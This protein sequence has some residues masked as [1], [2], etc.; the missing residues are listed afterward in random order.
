MPKV[1]PLQSSF[2]GGEITPLGYGL[3]DADKYK[4]GMGFCQNYIPTLQGPLL[5]RPGDKYV[6]PVADAT[7]PPVLIPFK[8]SATQAYML[9]FGHQYIRFY[10]N[11][12]QVLAT[13]TLYQVV[14]HDSNSIGTFT[15]NAVR[16]TLVPLPG[17]I[18]T[19]SVPVTAATPLSLSTPYS[20]TTTTQDTASIRYIQN[21]DVMY[22]FHPK[23]PVLK[24]Q[25][26]SNYEWTLKQVQFRDGPYQKLNTYTT[27]GDNVYTTMTP[28]ANLGAVTLT[29]GPT[30]AITGCANNGSGL[31]RVTAASST[32]R[33]T[34]DKIVIK[35]V[36][37]TTEANNVFNTT[38]AA[39]TWTITVV[40]NT[41]FDLIG[42]TFTNAYTSGGTVYPAVFMPNQQVAG[43][44]DVGRAF[45]CQASDG[46]RRWGY[47]FTVTDPSLAIWYTAPGMSA[48]PNL[49]ALSF[50][51]LGIFIPNS[52][53]T[54]D[55]PATACFHQN[56]LIL[57]GMPNQPQEVDGS[58]S[59]DFENFA[60]SN[61]ATLAV[62]DAYAYQFTLNSTDQN[63]IR[64][65]RS[66]AQGLLAGTQSSEW[67]L[68]ASSQNQA[69]SATNFSAS[70][71]SY[72]GSSAVDA[73]QAGNATLHLQSSSRKLRELNYFFQ[74]GTFRSTDLSEMA[75]HL[76]APGIVKLA[77]QKETQP[78]LWALR[79]DGMLLTMV[80]NRDDLTLKAGWARQPLG[81]QS[82]ASGTPPIVLSMAVIPSPDGSFEQLW[83][84]VK[85]WINGA[86]VVFIEYLTKPYDESFVQ[87]DAYHFDCGATYDNPITT[88]ALQIVSTVTI[89]TTTTLT[90]TFA[91]GLSN[92]DQVRLSSFVGLNKST[93]DI[94][95]NITTTNLVN[96]KAFT[97]AA[98][99]STTFQ[100]QDSYGNAIVSTGYSA[101]VAPSFIAGVFVNGGQIR[102][103]VSTVSGLT[104]LA[105][106]TVS[107][108]ADGGIH[109]DVVVSS[110]G[111]ITLNYPAAK[112]QIGYKYNSDGQNLRLEA[113]AADGT[114]I[115][116]IRRPERAAFMLRFVG[117]FAMGTT[118][119]NLIPTNFTRADVN[120]AD[121]ATTLF[122]GIHRD[123]VESS[124]DFE[125]QIC[126]RQNSG[127]PGMVQALAVFMEEF[128]V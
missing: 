124:Y 110:G 10:Q 91:H 72:F 30:A 76:T 82:D 90:T 93:T 14:G 94:N 65:L 32:T 77:V 98:V 5:R 80:Y 22:L 35:G 79:S 96:G 2:N 119:T 122:S 47:I 45:A 1:T 69:M 99:T 116:K 11:G 8:F 86:Q 59:G 23:Y 26:Y 52:D 9:E 97:V 7:N 81:G 53:T 111:V 33:A 41:T 60:P 127:L 75:E 67:L 20:G 104:W 25:R 120:Q 13:G 128:D 44:Q 117:D 109:P 24:L 3:V 112:V 73:V 123:G 12:G 31:I 84:V 108:L 39:M 106:E 40:T 51:Q 126:W 115:G 6:K 36:V 101:Y 17:E 88:V 63:Q 70:Q 48:L 105:N 19:A 118:F 15:F 100:I 18:I 61:P 34:G 114:S 46:I 37:G 38:A 62:T 89:G 57:G 102:K 64:W 83:M 71:T 49:T 85:R 50:W 58:V 121:Q 68:A 28:S 54:K 43:F 74:V 66:S 103:M 56:R 92:G 29:T 16:S 107:I 113:G 21:G 78:L 4:H 42:S 55:F 27:I 95:G 87:E 125:G